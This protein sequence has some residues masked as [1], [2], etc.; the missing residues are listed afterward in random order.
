MGAKGVL[1]LPVAKTHEPDKQALA[2]LLN[3]AKGD[4]TLKEF[5]GL[6]NVN[7]ST[8]TRIMQQTNR[9][10]STLELIEA[11]ADNAAPESGVTLDALLTANGYTRIYSPS[12]MPAYA[13]HVE[14]MARNAILNGLLFKNAEVHLESTRCQISKSMGFQ[15][16]IQIRTDLFGEER[17]AW[18]LEVLPPFIRTQSGLSSRDGKDWT[19]RAKQ[20]ALQTISRLSLFGVQASEEQTPARYSIVT[21]EKQVFSLLVEEFH[22]MLV[23]VAL[24]LILV[25]TELGIVDDE[26]F[27]PLADGNR[28]PQSFFTRERAAGSPP[29]SEFDDND[30]RVTIQG[31]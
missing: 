3:R 7:P 20:K 11:I 27:L 26:F 21:T 31:G 12:S 23:P 9:G 2:A 28:K 14:A 16:D 8:L 4:R 29:V 1:F 22:D 30:D 6:C 13:S 19:A 17:R 24:S 25:D 5:A 18:A 10:S 15:P